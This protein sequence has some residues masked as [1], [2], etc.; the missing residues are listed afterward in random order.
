MDPGRRTPHFAL[1]IP[2]SLSPQS[3]WLL[4]CLLLVFCTGCPVVSNLPAPGRESSRRDPIHDRT[5]HFYVPS[6]YH[7]ERTWP[8]LV[9][10]HGTKPFDSASAQFELWKGWAQQQGFLL[11]APELEGVSG[12]AGDAESQLD[13]QRADEAVILSVIDAVRASHSVDTKQIFMTG[14]SAGCYAV[15]YTGLKHPDIFR[16]IS[17]AQGNF[18][19]EFFR[20]CEPFMDR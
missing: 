8:V 11:V 6:H 12:L 14:W 5:Y 4:T 10:C 3:T 9:A 19:P 13:K 17:L 7:H 16:A 18:K 15:L 20:E 2:R 1:R